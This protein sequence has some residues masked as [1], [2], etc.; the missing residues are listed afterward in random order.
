MFLLGSEVYVSGLICV[1][2]PQGISWE[3]PVEETTR[4]RSLI[5][6]EPEKEQPCAHLKLTID[7]F[8]LHKMLGKGSF[9]KVSNRG[10]QRG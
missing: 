3:S 7:D 1:S 10:A 9:G 6:S 2:E 5:E 4:P 8:V